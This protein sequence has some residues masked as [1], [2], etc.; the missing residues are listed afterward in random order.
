MPIGKLSDT[1]MAQAQEV[2]REY[3]DIV[4]EM[5]FQFPTDMLFAMRAVAIL[6][7][8]ATSLDPGFDPWAATLPFAER[9]AGAEGVWDWQHWADDAAGLGRLLMRLPGRVDRF[10]AEAERGELISQYSLAPD[11]ARALRRIERAVD[12]LTVEL[13][14]VGLLISGVI[15]RTSE[16]ANPLSTGLLVAAGVVFLWGLIK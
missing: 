14:A 1:A 10:L 5:P 9:M 6:S 3:R 2:I 16:G 15:L 7:G 11:A 12:R 13:V 4:F 8:M